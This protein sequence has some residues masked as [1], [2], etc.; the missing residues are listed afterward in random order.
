MGTFKKWNSLGFKQLLP[1]ADVCVCACRLK[2]QT[3]RSTPVLC[4]QGPQHRGAPPPSL[5]QRKRDSSARK[6]STQTLWTPAL[7]H[8]LRPTALTL[9]P[10]PPKKTRRCTAPCSCWPATSSTGGPPPGSAPTTSGW[11]T[12]AAPIRWS[13]TRPW[14][15]SPSRTGRRE[16]WKQCEESKQ[17]RVI[18]SLHRFNNY[19]IFHELNQTQM[20][21]V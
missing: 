18:V 6:C 3:H 17:E 21:G 19:T 11:S 12:S 13:R 9:S 7:T 16:V 15:S 4:P 1:G 10:P 14:S 2:T 5:S 20:L 8:S